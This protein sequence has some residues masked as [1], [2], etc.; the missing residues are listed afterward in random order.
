M[1]FLFSLWAFSTSSHYL[2]R[3]IILFSFVSFFVFLYFAD[4]NETYSEGN[5]DTVGQ[6]VHYIMSNEGRRRWM[7]EWIHIVLN[8]LVVLQPAEWERKSMMYALYTS[9]SI[10]FTS[11]VYVQLD[12]EQKKSGPVCIKVLRITLLKKKNRRA[13]NFLVNRN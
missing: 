1:S 5:T 6:I 4:M 10:H 13:Q 11:V 12:K 9:W 7:N 8:L 3:I 2:V